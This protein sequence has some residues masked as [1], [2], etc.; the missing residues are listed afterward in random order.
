MGGNVVASSARLRTTGGGKVY[1]ADLSAIFSLMIIGLQL[2]PSAGGSK[3][4]RLFRLHHS[5]LFTPAAARE[6]LCHLHLKVASGSASTVISYSVAAELAPF[7]LDTI[8]AARLL[9][10]PADRTRASV[11]ALS[12]LQPTPKGVAVLQSFAE[13]IGMLRAKWP[14]VLLLSLNLLALL[15]LERDAASDR[16]LYSKYLMHLLFITMMGR[17]PN[18]WTPTSGPDPVCARHTGAT[19]TTPPASPIAG[20]LPL[21]IRQLYQISDAHTL[22]LLF[23]SPPKFDA[24]RDPHTLSPLHHKYFTNPES[25]SHVQ[26]YTSCGLRVFANKPYH[27]ATVPISFSGKAIVQW[28]MDCTDLYRQG[29]AVGVGGLLLRLRLIEPVLGAPS[30]A[31]YEEFSASRHAHYQLSAIGLKVCHWHSDTVDGDDTDSFGAEAATLDVDD[32]TV[33]VAPQNVTLPMVLADPGLRF[34]FREHLQAERCSENLDLYHRLRTFEAKCS[35]VAKLLEL[36]QMTDQCHEVAPKVA[37]ALASTVGACSE[38]ALDVYVKYLCHD[39]PN[40]VNID[41]QLR[42]RV[43][44]TM[45]PPAAEPAPLEAAPL[46]TPTSRVLRQRAI[47]SDVRNNVYRLMQTDSF[48]RFLAS[49]LYRDAMSTMDVWAE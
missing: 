27:H 2:Q 41:L 8:F 23:D 22:G 1:D 20:S 26:Y 47:M 14:R 38:I 17:A 30:T 6:S 15:R 12:I 44:E 45:A 32:G 42:L 43:E 16:V 9:H 34:L 28:L 25:D 10:C 21:R 33:L 37:C 18:V 19:A 46:A 29:Q 5:Y 31:N 48:R 13:S 7:L 36:E 3:A 40:M 24:P 39:A 49:E 11:T 35:K 4:A